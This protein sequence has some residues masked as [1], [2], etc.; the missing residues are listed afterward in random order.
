MAL[1]TDQFDLFS[2]TEAVANIVPLRGNTSDIRT[3][4]NAEFL[5]MFALGNLGYDP[6]QGPRNGPVDVFFQDR[7][8]PGVLKV[9]A[10]MFCESRKG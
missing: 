2:R 10:G 4:D 5:A 7:D 1:I 3:G 9:R 6:S 8:I